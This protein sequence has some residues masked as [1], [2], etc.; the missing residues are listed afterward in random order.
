MLHR[1]IDRCFFDSQFLAI[2]RLRD[3]W[4]LDGVRGVF[5]LG[6]L[7]KDMKAN[8]SLINRGNLFAFEH[9][10]YDYEAIRKR[11]TEYILKQKEKNTGG[12]WIPTELDSH[13][14]LSRHEEID[15]L[16]GITADCR[17]P[18][19][20][21]RVEVLEYLIEK[22]E[23][24]SEKVDLHV[25][26]FIAHAASPASRESE[27]VDQV[28]ITLGYLWDAHRVICQ[29]ANFVDVYLLS[30]AN[31]T[32]LSVPQFDHFKF[33]SNPLVSKDQIEILSQ[34]WHEF[35]RETESWGAWGIRALQKEVILNQK[36]GRGGSS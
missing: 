2:R 22:V 35:S 6:P 34:A 23:N 18:G 17:A 7:L 28:S 11:E 9:L 16:C 12:V 32:F 14:I 36:S 20:A 5:S 13:S 21:I 19:D 30:R 10:E 15:Y 8:V 31:H 29:V 3:A 26:K 27:N 1:F 25:R 33:I 4:P 24:A